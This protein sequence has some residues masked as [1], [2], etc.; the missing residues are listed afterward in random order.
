MRQSN[1]IAIIIVGKRII[2]MTLAVVA[3]ID[4]LSPPYLISNDSTSEK[5]ASLSKSPS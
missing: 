4:K 5:K 2:P 1:K 3:G